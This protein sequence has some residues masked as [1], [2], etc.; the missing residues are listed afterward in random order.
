M[1]GHSR[2]KV[3]RPISSDLLMPEFII[4]KGDQRL[5]D[6][7]IIRKDMMGSAMKTKKEDMQ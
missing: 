7:I 2:W 4:E 1:L 5:T 3:Y 6:T